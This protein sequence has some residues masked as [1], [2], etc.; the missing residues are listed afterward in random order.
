M[1]RKNPAKRLTNR[2]QIRIAEMRQE[3]QQKKADNNLVVFERLAQTELLP[4]EVGRVV[5]H[6]G[7]NVEIEDANGVRFR[8]AVRE[9]AGMEPVCGD[10]VS[11][12]RTA[13]T[14]WQGVIWS[15]L[16]R[17]N[18]LPRPLLGGGIQ[19][20]A[21][22]IDYLLVTLS[23]DKPNLGL[24]DRYLVAAEANALEPVI[25]LNKMD[26]VAP[27]ATPLESFQPYLSMGYRLYPISAVTSAGMPEL[28]LLLRGK[29]SVLAGHSGVGKS[30]IIARWVND[31]DKPVIGES[32]EPTGQGRHTTTVARLH[33][34][35]GGGSLIDSPGVREFGLVNV[36]RG[37]LAHFFRDMA[38]HAGPCRFADC[39]HRHE[40]GCCVKAAV[41]S[42]NV[43]QRR[44]DS[45]VRIF[46]SLPP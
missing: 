7:F 34:L 35:P 16:E 30:S 1:P 8:C 14:P 43:T 6:F 39:S 5:A 13:K 31:E 37:S 12:S 18:A 22:N 46:D 10:L 15:I 33:H 29:I 44:Y 21:A 26:L 20:T 19:T 36:T 24:L 3:R 23:A 40:P 38:T 9:T 25:V 32:H 11:L 27:Q 41:S 28:E 42:G 45:M 17:K 2:Q 4:P